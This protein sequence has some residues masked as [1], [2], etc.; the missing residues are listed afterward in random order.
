MTAMKRHTTL[1]RTSALA[2][3]AS[4]LGALGTLTPA[5]AQVSRYIITLDT[6][7]LSGT[8]GSLDF[9]FNPGG[10]SAAAATLQISGFTT[11]GA[12]AGTATDTGGGTGTLP[13]T[14][15]IANTGNFNDVFQGITFGSTLRFF[16]TLTSPLS[17]SPVGSTFS[18]SVLDP[19]GTTTLL[20]NNPD[21]SVLDISP[22]STTTGIQSG[23]SALTVQPIPEA[24]TPLSLG[25]LLALGAGGLAA[26]RRRRTPLAH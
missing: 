1:R 17:N 2:L 21:G 6:S 20:G 22:N 11:T 9:Q 13:G 23:S 4:A 7:T 24:S 3:G 25:L 8:P 10:A 12:L 18:F 15:L 14:L 5:Q 19:T 16:A 26:A